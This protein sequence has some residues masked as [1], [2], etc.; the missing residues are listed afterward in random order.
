MTIGSSHV[1]KP[2]LGRGPRIT[3]LTLPRVSFWYFI[4]CSTLDCSL[5]LRLE[6][7]CAVRGLHGEYANILSCGNTVLSELIWWFSLFYPCIL[8]KS[9]FFGGHCS[10]DPLHQ[11]LSVLWAHSVFFSDTRHI[12][13]PHTF[14]W[15]GDGWVLTSWSS[16]ASFSCHLYVGLHSFLQ[17]K[18]Y[19][20]TFFSP[21]PPPFARREGWRRREQW[22]HCA[23]KNRREGGSLQGFLFPCSACDSFR[24]REAVKGS[25]FLSIFMKLLYQTTES[26]L[27]DKEYDEMKRVREVNNLKICCS[28]AAGNGINSAALLGEIKLMLALFWF[29]AAAAS[30]VLLSETPDPTWLE[31]HRAEL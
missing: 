1:C 6:L 2:G 15:N 7:Q 19:V 23:H 13:R 10:S 5:P 31:I 26:K 16:T 12:Y 17:Q 21:P 28:H 30:Y 3:Y 20:G 4:Q 18:K 24:K 27:D 11:Q 9:L 25:S 14:P 8:Q 29:R 22:K